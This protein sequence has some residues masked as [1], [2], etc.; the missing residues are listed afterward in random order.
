MI[1]IF[2]PEAKTFNSAGIIVIKP[3]SCKENKKKSLNGWNLS[4]RVDIKYKDYLIKDNLVV[5]KS[6]SKVNPQAFRLGEPKTINN[7]IEVTA[8]HVMF[9]AQNYFLYDVRPTNKT[10]LQALEYIN[11]RTDN[12]SPFYFDS[13]VE[14]LD[15]C[16]FETK[17]LLE[18]WKIIEDRY[19]AVFDADNYHISFKTTLGKDIGQ[20]LV[21]NKN[22]SS[23]S[24]YE[25][26]S[27]VV[28]R[29]YP[30]G[31]NGLKLPERFLDSDISYSQPYT[32]RIDF[33]SD[34]NNSSESVEPT[35]DDLIEELRNKAQYYLNNNKYPKVSYEITANINE[36]YDV[37]DKLIVKHP[38]VNL[39]TEVQE[40]TYDHV[41]DK[42]ESVIIGNYVR[43]LKDKIDSIK[44]SIADVIS[45]SSTEYIKKHQKDLINSLYKTGFIYMDENEILILD[46]IPKE[47]AKNV[48]R[49]N[50]GGLAFSSTGYEG[51]FDVAIT[52][53]GMINANFINVGKMSVE[54]IEGLSEL[55]LTVS[56]NAKNSILKNSAS[57]NPINIADA[58][59]FN[60][61]SESIHF[62][63]KYIFS[64]CKNL[65][66]ST[67][68]SGSSGNLVFTV[69]EDKSIVCNGDSG[70]K[71]HNFNVG[72]L[73]LSAGKYI[74]S[75]CPSG[76]SSSKS[77]NIY[78]FDE[79]SEKT[80][81]TDF[82]DSFVF[83]ITSNTLVRVGITICP[84]YQ[85]DNLTFFPMITIDGEN[86]EYESPVD[87]STPTPEYPQKIKTVQGITNE[88]DVNA[89][90][91]NN[92]IYNARCTI[93]VE[94]DELVLNCTG[95]NAYVGEVVANS[96]ID[97][98]QK[99][100]K[101]F[102]IDNTE[103][104]AIV[105]NSQ[106]NKNYIQFW[107]KDKKSISYQYWGGNSYVRLITP[108]NAKYVSF[109]FG[110]GETINGD[111]LR[112]KIMLVKGSLPNRYVP[113][114]RWL[115]RVTN[116]NI[117]IQRFDKED[118][119]YLNNLGQKVNNDS[120]TI[121][122]FIEVLPGM[123]CT[124][125]NHFLGNS[126][127]TC[128]YDK[129]KNFISSVQYNN[130]TAIHFKVPNN[131]K[132][133]R[134]SVY[135]LQGDYDTFKFMYGD[136]YKENTALIDM[137][138]KSL[139]SIEEIQIG[140]Q[141]DG[142]K[143]VNRASIL[144][145]PVK[146]NTQYM[147]DEVFLPTPLT[148]LR[149]VL[150][151]SNN[152]ILTV[153]TG[154]FITTST[155]VGLSI[156]ILSNTIITEDMLKDIKLNLY[157]GDEPYFEFLEAKSTGDEFFDGKLTKNVNKLVLTGN[158]NFVEC[159]ETG[160][161]SVNLPLAAKDIEANL[162]VPNAI[163]TH[164]S[165][166]ARFNVD[167]GINDKIFSV[168][169]T[170]I[171]IRFNKCSKAAEFKS[172]LKAEYDAGRPV[173]IYYEV[174]EPII[175]QLSYE[176]LKLHEGYNCITLTG[177][178]SDMNINYYTDSPFNKAYAYRSELD[179]TAK[180]I[181]AEV[182]ADLATIDKQIKAS[183]ELC[184][185]ENDVGQL[186]SAINGIANLIKFASDEFEIDS[187]Y[188]K[189]K[190]GKIISTGGTIGNWIIADDNLHSDT[191]INGVL[192]RTYLQPV[193]ELYGDET[194]IFS[195]QKFVNDEFIDIYHVLANGEIYT[196]S[197]IFSNRNIYALGDIF[198]NNGHYQIYST[199]NG[200]RSIDVINDGSS[201]YLEIVGDAG[202]YRTS[203]NR[204][205]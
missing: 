179:M 204:T 194:M 58:G 138:K 118:G 134:S 128:F 136:E 142:N 117:C 135:I 50:M 103:Y 26:W 167:N 13:D 182:S 85:I 165:T 144:N 31:E 34:L 66:K 48:W 132:Y 75:G 205:R 155:T 93:S 184:I 193:L 102:K 16:Y 61:I 18:A 156:E 114:G 183:L 38:L 200:I 95:T 130:N 107:D 74:L 166:D 84:R 186:S 112:T 32:K 157:E 90:V 203:L 141:W 153:E 169:S 88:F 116:N 143:N 115:E 80:I 78:V 36:Q 158:E 81:G 33:T 46:K 146:S 110:K 148:V 178:C 181:L 145:I 53:D 65:I 21:H 56:N 133:I 64:K 122:D 5:I 127:S 14:G 176:L 27:G 3:I 154:A 17:N 39:K 147:L 44:D 25:D 63:N 188:F 197:D 177:E 189:L 89:Y 71:Y 150:Y 29:I 137:N 67:A 24:S 185:K 7:K 163:S 49:W 199:N 168:D 2:P 129:D 92:N 99:Y 43:N 96:G 187:T 11:E 40:Y 73:S 12:E 83:E 19:N 101:L 62:K 15:T 139:V 190:N 159:G 175:Y 119:Y 97:Y 105:T 191:V 162:V 59:N 45:A 113:P 160:G 6:K 121:T 120:F 37:N 8:N 54:R 68:I 20:M 69:N 91:V 180:S 111:K 22:I 42:T 124:I 164:F 123:N 1:K 41:K 196:N 47:E 108:L 10:A 192:Y 77:F 106:F 152:D 173:I 51:P 171:Y 201:Y 82:G 60:I 72:N 125:E 149:C 140:K 70:F 35:E 76:G 202:T 52:M 4:L 195:I 172:F 104:S 170:T 79:T 9:D 198:S 86:Q 174:D 87:T 94:K 151:N 100:G 55:F 131:C 98:T 161:F 57:G 30:V 109:R 23:F 126:P 28:T